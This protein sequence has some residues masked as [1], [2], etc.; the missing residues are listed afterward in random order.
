MRQ[1]LEV[2]RPIQEVDVGLDHHVSL[3]CVHIEDE[4]YAL[5]VHGDAAP[6]VERR[7]A[8][9]Q[10]SPGRESFRRQP[11]QRGLDAERTACICVRC[12]NVW[13]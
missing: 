10:V 2:H 4:V 11:L 8:I 7:A 6:L 9:A 1:L 3:L 12:E 5:E 13:V